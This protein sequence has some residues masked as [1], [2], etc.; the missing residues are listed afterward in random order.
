MLLVWTPEVKVS[1]PILR[2]FHVLSTENQLSTKTVPILK[3]LI[4]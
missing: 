4:S 3:I 1:F 2:L